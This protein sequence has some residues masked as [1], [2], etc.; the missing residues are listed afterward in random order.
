[1][2]ND[3][4][5]SEEIEHDIRDQRAQMSSSINSLQQKFSVDAILSDIGLM[6]RG[7]AGDIGRSVSQ[8]LGQNPAAVAVIG[9]GVAWLLLGQKRD[10]GGDPKR[11][12][13]KTQ[14][15]MSLSRDRDLGRS[16]DVGTTV[17]L[18]NQAQ[19]DQDTRWFDTA[20]QR[21]REGFQRGYKEPNFSKEGEAGLIDQA[22]DAVGTVGDAVSQ[23]ATSI[24]E[25]AADLSDWLSHGLE[26]LSDEARARV[27]QARH[28]AHEAR[29]VS[30]VVIEKGGR[31]ASHLFEDQPLIVGA[32]AVAFGAALGGILPHS[33][34]EDDSLGDSSDRLFAKAQS[35][36]MSEREKAV[37]LART[38]ASDIGDEVALAR[39]ELAD[40]VPEGT[41]VGEI[42]VDRGVAA[43]GRIYDHATGEIEHKVSDKTERSS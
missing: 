26:D 6:F 4:R 28:A 11:Q 43:V 22:L 31:T 24:G 35:L 19:R 14:R 13:R 15:S 36:M 33:K 5:S 1:M 12:Y 39:S 16:H 3:A 10:G 37:A 20:Q 41:T 27:V 21:G 18:G 30:D 40:L 34:L 8:T 25:T 29:R 17:G 9:A 32:L 7:Q 38:A 23:G 42:I 2:T